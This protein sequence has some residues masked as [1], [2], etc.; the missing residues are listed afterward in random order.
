MGI[1]LPLDCPDDLHRATWLR[2]VLA[3]F[4]LAML[5]AT[6]RLWT[7]QT[8]FPRVP[9][10]YVASRLPAAAEWTLATLAVVALFVSLAPAA[11][12]FARAA[13]NAFACALALLILIDQHRLQPWSYQAM[14]VAL[15]LANCRPQR[16]VTLVRLLTVSI[17]FYSALSKLDY[18]FLHTLGPQMLGA[19]LNPLGVHPAD[20]APGLRLAAA[21]T[22]PSAELLVAAGFCFRRLWRAALVA[23]IAT[24]LALLMILGPWGL[25]HSLAVLL[26]NGYFIAQNCLLFAAHK[27]N[28]HLATARAEPSSRTDS[29]TLTQPLPEGKGGHSSRQLSPRAGTP[30]LL[31]EGL[32]FA[33]LVL[34]LLEPWG[35][36]DAWPSWALYAPNCQRVEVWIHRSAVN[37]L[38]DVARIAEIDTDHEADNDAW[39]RLRIDRWS[40]AALGAPLYPQ[41]RF[42]LGVAAALAADP[43][44]G[45]WLRAVEFSRADRISGER[46]HRTLS[47]SAE[48]DAALRP[49]L[50]NARPARTFLPAAAQVQ[51]L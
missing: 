30:A 48:I 22:L 32:I 24:H 45:R 7:V 37:R 8:V 9:L 47:G 13:L 49:F 44:M 23:S 3:A 21:A 33:A 18:T 29:R 25:N 19:L 15:A 31:T 46:Q 2:R 40:L 28:S 14:L 17:Y 12:R 16:A 41:N 1:G 10:V 50:L 35:L 27:E 4:V 51:S 43:Q 11:D 38:G 36:W 42:Q 39:V 6:W 26:W 34:P 5:A 20:W